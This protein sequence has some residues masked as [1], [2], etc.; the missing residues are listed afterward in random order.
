MIR[1]KFVAML[2]IT[3]LNDLKARVGQQLGVSEWH[4]VGQSDIDVFADLTHDH[5]WIHVDVERATES[6]FGG[7]IA[8]G[9]FTLALVP[10]LQGTVFDVQGI[11]HGLNYGLDRVRFPAPMPVGSAVRA[12]VTLTEAADRSGGVQAKFTTVVESDASE[13]PVCIADSLVLYYGS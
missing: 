12:R 8:H 5:Q 11:T 6:A 1:R 10:R 2:I 7:T 13:K 4:H 9:F 3:G